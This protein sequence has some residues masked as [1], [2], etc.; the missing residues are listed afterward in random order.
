MEADEP[1][2]RT[3]AQVAQEDAE[4][5]A[6]AAA[7]VFID[8]DEG[9]ALSS[10]IAGTALKEACA[11]LNQSAKCDD[12]IRAYQESFGGKSP[13]ELGSAV[14]TVIESLEAPHLKPTGILKRLTSG[15]QPACFGLLTLMQN[16]APA[17]AAAKSEQEAQ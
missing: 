16:L 15:V 2:T 12:A 9:E 3:F 1:P 5:H 17:A 7:E 11:S 4:F 10:L 14:R 13:E 8:K 6:A